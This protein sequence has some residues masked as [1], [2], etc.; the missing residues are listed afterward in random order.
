MKR[1]RLG[2][3]TEIADILSLRHNSTSKYLADTLQMSKRNVAKDIAELR[4]IGVATVGGS[5]GRCTIRRSDGDAMAVLP[6]DDETD[7]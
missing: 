7:I 2:N 4:R 5:I 6:S 3:T 1:T